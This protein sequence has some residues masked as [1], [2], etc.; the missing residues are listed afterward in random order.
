MSKLIKA[1]NYYE[2]IV[3]FDGQGYII[4]RSD[5]YKSQDDNKLTFLELIE[6]YRSRIVNGTL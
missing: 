2:S 3:Y 4:N 5:L 6:K 1:N